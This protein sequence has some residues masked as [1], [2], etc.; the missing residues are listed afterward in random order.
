VLVAAAWLLLAVNGYGQEARGSISGIVTD[1]QTAAVPGAQVL[2]VNEGTN[3]QSKTTTNNTGFFEVPLLNPGNYTVTVEAAGFK[4][5]VRNGLVLTVGTRLDVDM[6]LEVGQLAETV[7]VT[8]EA[9]LLETR[10]ASGGRIVSTREVAELPV[11][12]MNPFLMAGLAAG[13]QWTGSPSGMQRAFDVA[14]TT[15]FNTAGNV[16]QNEYTLDGAPV[17]GTNRR[18]GYVPPLDAVGEFKLETSSFDASYGHT[19]GATVNVSSRSGTNQLHGSLFDQH[20][21]NRWNATPH[22]TR[23]AYE[24]QVAAGTKKSSD[25]KQVS[26][27]SNNYGGT[28]SG[29]VVIPKVFNGKDKAF[30]LVTYNGY[31]V[32]SA[33]SGARSVPHESWYN[34]DF[35]DI[36]GVDATLYTIYDPRTS[37]QE[38]NRV[39]RTPFPGNKGIP[40][41]NP[42]YNAYAKI[43]PKATNVAGF[44]TREGMQN[45]FDPAV[46]QKDRFQSILNRNDYYF[47]DRHRFNMKWYRSERQDYTGDWTRDTVPGLHD[48]GGYRRNIGGSANHNWTVTPSDLLDITLSATRFIEGLR[49]PVQTAMKPTD[50]GF[51]PTWTRRRATI[52]TC[53]ASTSRAGCRTSAASMLTKPTAGGARRSS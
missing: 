5:S 31:A 18:V 3:A 34:G 48:G 25:P 32:D 33:G 44:V 22:F 10:S 21:Q 16:G 14:G 7:E 42:V 27:R 24:S 46:G 12:S 8:A 1:P 11:P 23:L 4:K 51:P 20:W 26:G 6:K 47:N 49:I 38:G 9:P 37:R 36:Q 41:L 30:F 15:S 19:S 28:I 17:T 29:P 13:M 52:T 39:V 43:Y 50:V 35:S 2:V 53:R 45:H 40:V